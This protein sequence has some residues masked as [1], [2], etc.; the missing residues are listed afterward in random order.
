MKFL[1]TDVLT[2]HAQLRV[3][4]VLSENFAIS[5]QLLN[6]LIVQSSVLTAAAD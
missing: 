6:N 2:E 5:F 1:I 4:D 3:S